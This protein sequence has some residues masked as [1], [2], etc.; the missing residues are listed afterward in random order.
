MP[1]STTVITTIAISISM[2]E[3][4]LSLF[5]RLCVSDECTLR[6][7]PFLRKILSSGVV[8]QITDGYELLQPAVDRILNRHLDFF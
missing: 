1:P 6:N 4:P 7:D 8:V 2:I 3:K 5:R